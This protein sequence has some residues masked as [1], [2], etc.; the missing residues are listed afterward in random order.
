MNIQSK[1]GSNIQSRII[2]LQKKN[3][4]CS[5]WMDLENITSNKVTQ[6]QRD[7]CFWSSAPPHSKLLGMIIQHGVNTE[8]E[9]IDCGLGLSEE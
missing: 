4:M 1:Y 9:I 8:A 2:Q 5:E 6:A 3:E 7:K